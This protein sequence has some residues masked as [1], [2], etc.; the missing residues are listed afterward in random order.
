MRGWRCKHFPL[1]QAIEI[2]AYYSAQL[3]VAEIFFATLRIYFQEG[4]T[5]MTPSREDSRQR[6]VG[7]T[8]I[9]TDERDG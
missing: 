4:L 2:A 8:R 7:E 1:S 9:G 5:G 6:R 3:I